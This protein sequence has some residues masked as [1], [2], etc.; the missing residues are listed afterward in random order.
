[1]NS[2]KS[3]GTLAIILGALLLSLEVYSLKFIQL[4][5]MK[6][7]GRCFTFCSEYITIAPMSVAILITVGVIIYGI[8]LINLFKN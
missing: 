4:L 8:V 7:T 6:I 1:M 2:K 3:I 5:D